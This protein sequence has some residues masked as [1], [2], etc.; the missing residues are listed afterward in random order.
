MLADIAHDGGKVPLGR[1]LHVDPEA[2]IHFDYCPSS[3][4]KY[5]NGAIK[6]AVVRVSWN[7]VHILAGRRTTRVNIFVEIFS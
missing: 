7:A 6:L 3:L 4:L 5:T 1:I 2:L